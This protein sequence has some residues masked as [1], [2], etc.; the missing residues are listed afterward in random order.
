M[1][2]DINLHEE[3]L[4]EFP[5]FYIKRVAKGDTPDYL[6]GDTA[7]S[8]YLAEAK[9]RYASISFKNREFSKWR[10]QFSRIEVRDRHKNLRSLKGFIVGRIAGDAPD[11]HADLQGHRRISAFVRGTGRGE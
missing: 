2:Y 5:E 6:C 1:L 11:F 4:Y 9:G 3:N 10:K 8:V 7:S